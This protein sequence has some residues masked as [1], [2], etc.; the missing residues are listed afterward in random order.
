MT[1]HFPAF[2]TRPDPYPI[3]TQATIFAKEAWLYIGSLLTTVQ[4][5]M[6]L[7]GD[8]RDR[9]EAQRHRGESSIPQKGDL[10]G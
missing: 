4:F 6:T 5:R 2:V 9:D 7:Y 1:F 10:H 8:S 3:F